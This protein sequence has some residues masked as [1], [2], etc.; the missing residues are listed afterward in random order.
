MPDADNAFLQMAADIAMNHHEKWDGSGYP[1]GKPGKEIPVSG[2]IVSI[3]DV[4]DALRSERS[5]KEAYPVGRCLDIIRDME[6]TSFDPALVEI[7]MDC[8]DEFEEIRIQYS[9]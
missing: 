6:K 5:Y 8:I 7:F 9:E 2:Q 1:G 3:T 4:F